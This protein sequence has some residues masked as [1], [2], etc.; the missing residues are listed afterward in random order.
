MKYERAKPNVAGLTSQ[1]QQNEMRLILAG[2]W[3]PL[4][5]LPVFKYGAD[6]YRAEI[7]FDRT[8][9]EGVCRKTFLPSKKVE[10]RG[11]RI[12]ETAHSIL[13]YRP[14]FPTASKMKSTTVFE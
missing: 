12:T 14:I 4:K 8:R 10:K 9:G 3:P 6:E 5:P 2:L 7:H 1:L 11:G 13:N